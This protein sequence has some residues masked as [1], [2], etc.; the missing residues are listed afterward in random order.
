MDKGGEREDKGERIEASSLY[1]SLHPIYTH[2]I[3]IRKKTKSE[4]TFT[5]KQQFARKP[6]VRQH[7][8]TKAT[9][10]M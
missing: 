4:N 3:N 8:Y 10:S 9:I 5:Q 2:H 6:K 7:I 1:C